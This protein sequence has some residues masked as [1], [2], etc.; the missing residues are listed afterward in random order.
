MVGGKHMNWIFILIGL[1]VFFFMGLQSAVILFLLHLLRNGNKVNKYIPPPVTEDEEHELELQR[2][3]AKAINKDFQKLMSYS[4]EQALE[5]E[6][7][8]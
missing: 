5:S 8:M 1:V 6:K 7:V 2:E 4:V 3:R